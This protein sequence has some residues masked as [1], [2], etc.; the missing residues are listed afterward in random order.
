MIGTS[1]LFEG[2][3]VQGLGKMDK[4]EGENRPAD[5]QRIPPRGSDD[6]TIPPL[7]RRQQ[8]HLKFQKIKSDPK[9]KDKTLQFE[10]SSISIQFMLI[11]QSTFIEIVKMWID[12][13]CDDDLEKK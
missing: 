9:P 3:F 5:L 1:P 2:R 4:M 13:H 10:W 12:V 11:Q 6:F 8:R 7:V